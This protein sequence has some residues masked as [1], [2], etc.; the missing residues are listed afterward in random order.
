MKCKSI[1]VEKFYIVAENKKVNDTHSLTL[2]ID[3]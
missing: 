1:P 3:M 2:D